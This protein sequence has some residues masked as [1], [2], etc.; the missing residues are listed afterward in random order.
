LWSWAK[1][2]ELNPEK[3]F[4]TQIGKG[5]TAWQ[6]VYRLAKG[7]PPGKGYTA[8]QSAAE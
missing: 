2:A 7:M 6:R 8:W 5:Y 4:L 1:E 3:L